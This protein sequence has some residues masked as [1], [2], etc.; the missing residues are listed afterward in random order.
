MPYLNVVLGVLLH[1]PLPD[2]GHGDECGHVDEVEDGGDGED[3]EPEPHEHEDLLVD[4]VGGE[5]A[6]RVVLLQGARVT[7]LVEG[8]L[9]QPAINHN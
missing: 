8:A 7:V 9:G 1:H 6:E 3:D 5:H 2:A 4:D